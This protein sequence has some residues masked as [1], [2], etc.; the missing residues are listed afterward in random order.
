M[1]IKLLILSVFH[2]DLTVV[3]KKLSYVFISNDLQDGQINTIFDEDGKGIIIID[4]VALDSH[5]WQAVAENVWQ[6]DNMQLNIIQENNNSFLVWQS[7]STTSLIAIQNYQ[8]GDL[9]LNLP[10]YNPPSADTNHAPEVNET[11]AEQTVIVNQTYNFTLPENLFT[12]PDGDTLT[13]SINNLPAWLKFDPQTNTLSGIATIDQIGKLQLTITATDKQGLTATQNFNINIIN[14]P[15]TPPQTNYSNLTHNIITHIPFEH[16]LPAD[17]FTD[18]D[19]DALSYKIEDLP[20]GI[21]F[22]SQTNTISGVATQ[23]Q[24]IE[25]TIQCGDG[26]DY[27]YL[28][29]IINIIE[30]RP[31]KVKNKISQLNT[32]ATKY[33]EYTIPADLFTDP[34]GEI[35]NIN[36]NNL[37]QWLNYNPQTNT[38]NGIAPI[39]S[40]GINN[41]T[42]I[43]TDN[44]NNSIEHTLQINVNLDNI[45]NAIYANGLKIGTLKND[46]MI[47]NNQN[48]T[49]RGNAGD[50]TI[51]GLDGDD[52]IHG[53]IGNDTLNGGSGND[54][55]FGEVGN[56]SLNGGIGDDRLE[57]GLG[58]DAYHFTKG[59][60]KDSI[61]DLGGTETLHLHQINKNEIYFE[62]QSNNLI[63][64]IIGTN[65]QLTIQNHYLKF[66]GNPNA[67]ET[68]QFDNGETIDI[69]TATTQ[70]LNSQ[71]NS[72]SISLSNFLVSSE[73]NF[74]SDTS[75]LDQPIGNNQ[76][77]EYGNTLD[78]TISLSNLIDDYDNNGGGNIY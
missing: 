69:K 33:F 40:A 56:D 10:A 47:G 15:N 71:V 12:D 78:T 29:Y 37:P 24:L 58:N 38:I 8:N 22:N 63:I 61:Y 31:P 18:A 57:G 67:I 7:T 9:S 62:Q 36:V 1:R 16:A 54:K 41:I 6:T 66:L 14:N 26:Q 25:T 48:N 68:I 17:L 3:V 23:A 5:D 75:V 46:L 45:P 52:E 77:M 43:A 34:D 60:G 13:Y 74:P 2:L 65:D 73:I 21:N 28:P 53:G 50:D 39:E 27:S 51:H 44:A 4:G 19:N 55:I 42:I 49:I 32:G 70:Q 30:N 64:K 59:D 72:K 35:L 76:T 20:N 11:L